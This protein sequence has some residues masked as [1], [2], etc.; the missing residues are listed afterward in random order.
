MTT[1]SGRRRPPPP[2]SHLTT[3]GEPLMLFDHILDVIGNTPMVRL[4]RVSA[5]LE[6]APCAGQS[7]ANPRR[8]ACLFDIPVERVVAAARA[9]IAADD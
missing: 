6:C 1:R 8:F 9:R 7:C 3:D 2:F 5:G 4:H